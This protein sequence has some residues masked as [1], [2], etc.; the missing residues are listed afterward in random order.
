[1]SVTDIK[2]AGEI[3]HAAGALLIV[4]NTF[5]S[6]HLQKP[7]DLGADVVLHS[8]TKFINGHADI[9]GGIVVA[10][11]EAL[12]KQIR[13]MLVNLG[14]NMDPHQAYMVSRGIKTLALRVERA[15][16][17]ARKV[18]PWLEAHPQ[19]AWVRYIGLVSHPQHELAKRQMTGF[20]SMIA[21]DLKGGI[22]AGRIVMDNVQL[23]GLA[24]SLGG[25]ETLISH[26]ASMTH[27]SMARENRVAAGI[28]DGLVRLSVGIEDLEDILS[29]LDQALG[30]IG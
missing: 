10:K 8:V 11:T 22:E 12:H 29:D 28:T 15:E 30:R 20:G 27:A 19:V 2:A 1:M 25:V 17:N 4:D 5:A 26:P 14:A 21:F 23:A 16:E 13:A 24:V 9:V 18:A 3:A 7:L 6:P